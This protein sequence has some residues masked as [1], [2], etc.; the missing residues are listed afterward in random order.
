MSKHTPGPWI[1]GHMTDPEHSCNCRSI[2]AGGY[3]GSIAT[4]DVDNGKRIVDGGND[5]PPLEEAIANARLIAEAPALLELARKLHNSKNNAEGGEIGDLV[6][7]C[8]EASPPIARIEG[9][10][11]EI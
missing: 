7:L 9:E 6:K 10:T 5:S 3:A 1:A 4:I 11:D 2:L 8:Y